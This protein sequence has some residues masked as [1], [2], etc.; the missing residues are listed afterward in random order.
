MIDLFSPA[1]LAALAGYGSS[2][3]VRSLCLA[4]RVRHHLTEQICASH[5]DVHGR[6]ELRA[7]ADHEQP[8]GQDRSP[9]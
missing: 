7:A 2:S 6:R 4:C 9:E 8:C 3:E 5:P 1:I